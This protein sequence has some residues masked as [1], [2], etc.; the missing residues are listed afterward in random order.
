[1]RYLL[2]FLIMVVGLIGVQAQGYVHAI[3]YELPQLELKYSIPLH[4]KD[5]DGLANGMNDYIRTP[6]SGMS[7]VGVN[8]TF[9][10][11]SLFYKDRIGVAFY[12]NGFG[13]YVDN[14]GFNRYMANRYGG[15]Y[16]Y[17]NSYLFTPLQ[18]YGP[19][20]GVAYRFRYKSYVIEP[21]LIYGFEH[22]DDGG[23]QFDQVM[24]QKGTNQFLEYSIWATNVTPRQ[25]SYRGRLMIGKRVAFKRTATIWEGGF[26]ADF[27]YSPY[28]CLLTISQASYGSAPILQQ[29]AVSSI[30]RQLNFGAYVKMNLHRPLRR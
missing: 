30:Y 7:P 12:L 1:M 8:F 27:I 21:D 13:G 29:V 25:R 16:V 14:S 22:L 23:L 17:S 2:T 3:Q 9:R 18:F 19:A 26:V 5:F 4:S 11:V 20:V 28:N 6:W 10:P 24:R 15:E